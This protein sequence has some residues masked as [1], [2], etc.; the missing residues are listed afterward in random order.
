[1]S[2]PA[3]PWQSS[4]PTP[5]LQTERLWLRPW[6]AADRSP[7]AAL[8]ADP[9]VMAHFPACLSAEASDA[10]AQRIEAQIQA[11][12]WG[13]WAAERR[14]T[15]GFIGFIGL[16]PVPA[17]LPF[18][19][20][21]EIGWR[22]ARAHWGQGL[23][24]EGAQAAL[25]FGFEQL[26]LAEVLSFTAL[27]NERSRAVMR[28]L[29]L[30]HDDAPFEHPNLPEGHPLRPHCLY[31]LGQ[32]AWRARRPPSAAPAFTLLPAET[33]PAQRHGRPSGAAG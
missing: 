9:Q 22:L 13:L 2:E 11:R 30:Q 31:R 4:L 7:F 23:A 19:P 32:A 5:T 12:G 21:V 29:G 6:C 16:Q 28:R 14:D 15:R 24:T 18:A 3:S 26:G 1:M 8:N 10:G 27:G 25:A 17:V 20:A 33:A